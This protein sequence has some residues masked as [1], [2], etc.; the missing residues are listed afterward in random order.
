MTLA[1]L[2]Y[3]LTKASVTTS[4]VSVKTLSS[5]MILT[6][7]FMTTSSVLLTTVSLTITYGSL[8]V[9]SVTKVLTVAS[10]SLIFSLTASPASC[11]TT[12]AS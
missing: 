2:T 10:A 6:V 3:V 4:S 11:P 7:G 5:V 1:S 12:T 9:V 8:T